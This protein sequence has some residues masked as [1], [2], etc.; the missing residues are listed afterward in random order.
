MGKPV[1]GPPLITL[2]TTIGASTI[3]AYPIPSCMSEK[4]GPEVA[5]IDFAPASDAP[6]IDTM[7]ANS[8]SICIK[9]LP[10]FVSKKDNISAISVDGVIG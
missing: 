7:L 1:E 9:T 8:S 4:P 5:V 6:I 10:S 3:H 2:Q